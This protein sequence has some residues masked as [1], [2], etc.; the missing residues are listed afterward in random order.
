MIT[1]VPE[2]GWVG[3][4]LLFSPLLTFFGNSGWAFGMGRSFGRE[5]ILYS[6]L[7]FSAA[8]E[9][10]RKSSRDPWGLLAFNQAIVLGGCRYFP[11]GGGEKFASELRSRLQA[12]WEMP[13]GSF[14]KKEVRLPKQ[15]SIQQQNPFC[16]WVHPPLLGL[17]A[18]PF[19]EPSRLSS[20]HPLLP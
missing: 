12:R 6:R 8:F 20:G 2:E 19:G 14:R 11:A 5:W 4:L 13:K 17:A 15:K 9:P 1:L 18:P 16:L 3:G 7:L 10:F